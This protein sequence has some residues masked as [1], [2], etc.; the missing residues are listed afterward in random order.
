MDI[1]H[2]SVAAVEG[3]CITHVGSWSSFTDRLIYVPIKD[4]RGVTL[5]PG[6]FSYHVSKASEQ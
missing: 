1:I 4:M 2:N 3:D 6:L 5:M